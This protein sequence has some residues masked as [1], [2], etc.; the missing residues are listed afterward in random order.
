MMMM[1]LDV[2]RAELERLFELD[3]LMQLSQDVLGFDPESVGGTATL[4]SFAGALVGHCADVDALAALTDALAVTKPNVDRRIAVL[5]EGPAPQGELK[6]GE[7]LGAYT[8]V[9]KLGDGRLGTTYVARSEG[10]EVR[11]KVLHRES[12]RDRRGVHRYLT[13]TRLIARIDHP[14]LPKLVEATSVD[15]RYLVAHEHV[16]GQSL[17]AR[18]ARTGPMHINEARALLEG[19]AQSL[20]ALHQRGLSH[21]DVSLENVITYRAAD[22]TQGVLLHD[23]G[24][25]RLRARVA[26]NRVGLSSTGA[27]HKTVS[28]E[29]IQ[30]ADP[31]ARSD[32]YSFGA[33]AYEVLS[34]K[35]VFSGDVL[36]TAFAHLRE[37]PVPPSSIAPRGWVT[38]ELDELVLSL[39][40]KSPAER[41]KNATEVLARL[42][43]AGRP[44]GQEEGAI[45]DEEV[46][47]LEQS[48]LGDATNPEA[49]LALEAAI[50]RGARPGRVAQALNF[51]ASLID[52][53]EDLESKRGLLLRAARLF[54]GSSDTLDRA[55]AAYEALLV[56]DA[57]DEVALAG[58]EEVR[59][60]AGRFEE[61]L[62]LLLGRAEAAGSPEE[63][64]RFMGEIGRLYARDVGDQEQAVVAYT[65]ALC[66]APTDEIFAHE[67]ERLV[68]TNEG[69]WGEVLSSM[70]EAAQNP[71][72]APDTRNALL[73]RL[74]DWYRSKLSR[75]DLAL[76][77][78]QAV[79]ASEPS[80][81]HALVSLTEVY[82]KAQQWAE[83]GM[84]LTRRADA[85]ATP[86]QA[87]DLRTEAAEIL[88]KQMGDATS[89]RAIYEQVLSE[90]PTHVRASDALSRLYDGARDFEGLVALLSRRADAQRGA[91]HVRTL[92]RIAEIYE[93]R[94]NDADEAIRRYEAA[95]AVD[96]ASLDALR[97]L[98]R[99]YTKDGKYKELLENLELQVKAAATPKQRVAL[100]ERMAS[101]YEEEFLDHE[102]AAHVLERALQTDPGRLSAMASLV[103]FYR[104]LGRWDAAAKLYERQLQL[105]EAPAERVALGMAWG[106]VLLEQ[107]GSPER[108]AHAYELVL[109]VDA[110]H[111]GA[112]E[113]LAKLRQSSGDADAALEAILA[114]AEQA[115]SPEARSEHYVRAARLLEE[116]GDRDGAID[117][118]R[119]ALDAN[120]RDK[121][122][123]LALR[124]AYVARGDVASAVEL[125]EREMERTEGERAQAKL[126]GEL[127]RLLH[128]RLGDPA[129][130]ESA[131]K[132]A[133]LLDPG[134]IDALLVLGEVAFDD[135]RFVEASAHY[136]RLA[137]R[138]EALGHD[139][140]VRVLVR[141]VD[142]LSKSGSTERA[143]S[144]MDTLLRL[145]PDNA[146]A[147][148]R[149][150]LVTFEH[151]APRRAAELL[152]DYLE[153]FGDNLP[154]DD[155]ALANYRLGESLRRAGE[156]D[157]AVTHLE[158]ACDLDPRLALPLASLAQIHTA[159][160]DWPGV[161]RAKTRH[162]DVA[163]ADDRVQ[164]LL[165]IGEIA[166]AKL[167]DRTQATKSYVA[168][169]EERPDDRK[170]LTKLMQLYSE[171][172]DWN[173]LVEVVLKLADFV[174]DPA[175]KVKYLHTAAMVTAR[176]IG[177]TV[178]AA[179]YFRQV[180]DLDP[181]NV[182][183]LE[184]FIALERDA[185]NYRGVEELLQQRLLLAEAAEDNSAQLSVYD[186]LAEL[187]ETRLGEPDNAITALEVA[188]ELDP[189]H[190][191]R[192][193]KLAALYEANGA[194][195]LERAVAL[196]ERLLAQN[197]YRH[198]SYKALRKIYT[199]NRDADASWALCQA[200]TVLQLAEPDEERFYGRM[201][202]DT[203][204]AAQEAFS[205]EDWVERVMHPTANHLLTA[206]FS[207]IEPTVVQARAVQLQQLG[208]APE[209][210]IDPA[211]HHAPLAQTLY[212]AAGVLGLPLPAVY[213]NPNDPG[214]LSFLSTAEPSLVLGRVGISSEVPA[215]VAAFVAA[216]QLAYYRPGMYL[217]HF[218]QTGTGLKSWLFAAIKLT[219]PQF[220]IAQDLEGPVTE[221]L[222][223]LRASLNADVKEL[224]S[225]VVSKLIQSGN[226]LD[227]KKWVAAVDLTADRAGF[228]VAHDLD[229]A[230]QVVRA[231]EEGSAS[232]SNQERFKEL[233]LYST[234]AKYFALRRRLGIAVDS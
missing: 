95:L 220:P 31:D 114:L 130:A 195:Y 156:L 123:A 66:D 183:A 194:E 111:T 76:P 143:L 166:S 139:Q 35:P 59:K 211:S 137:E 113:A 81:D 142:A 34:G 184:E 7:K 135:A 110:E 101:V 181:R 150:A 14:S 233:I 147:L 115:A 188:L 83:L 19:I 133:V 88:E 125:L 68:G 57:G 13:L 218:I 199:S 109:Q 185:G 171:E 15:G 180:L 204:A 161:I 77:C 8:I 206:V 152:T 18:I 39:L 4:G 165:D 82:R 108:A 86:A 151:G 94:L 103:R 84:V 73:L 207:L 197:P 116:R 10:R 61:L 160:E 51:A 28:P 136:G 127:A 146:E 169:L 131:A 71:E 96:S 214:G 117:H 65:Q 120:P 112:L 45:S 23:A 49:A 64:A 32:V 159:R 85:A 231:S 158:E 208:F 104:V 102:K 50:S 27:S 25:D 97:G 154:D 134:N 149:V 168:A 202:A 140:A 177:D 74:G 53:E 212:Y 222:A 225:S 121:G 78:L 234:S 67:I 122:A 52:E 37:V 141:Y 58:L 189:E 192:T 193:D 170:L 3:E 203:A 145:A 164:L 22:G 174:D 153:R 129:R 138:A 175:Q 106:R 9:R 26:R 105:V 144:P 93:D 70:T 226:P 79:L 60:R 215:Q 191:E 38:R 128:E 182:K 16:E 47:A 43:G 219:A 55:D 124:A 198:D 200:L 209:H 162:L 46:D 2:L 56:L 6:P 178:Q 36:Q 5:G 176:Q 190:K 41:P 69:G 155:R 20:A 210:R 87:R 126:A 42:A 40:A 216:R 89:A 48:L 163:S 232:V 201:R 98:E 24:S 172:K 107:I 1:E 99:V 91:D 148:A 44:V 90:D 100:F 30:G 132:R 196:Q 221:A 224:L 167:G 63:R 179:Q 205:E 186:S 21:G 92:C 75:P 213:E 173:K 230:V 54:E 80:N 223:A 187:Y 228:I 12:T 29:Q 227:L 72:L 217:R 33:L 157:A 229:T 119:Q 11:L 62:E 118:Y 17:Q